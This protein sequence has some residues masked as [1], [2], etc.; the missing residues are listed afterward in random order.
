MSPRHLF[1]AAAAA[2]VLLSG[3]GGGGSASSARGRAE[4]RI[5]WPERSRYLPAYADR[6]TIKLE[7]PG[8]SVNRYEQT[9]TRPSVL[10]ATTTVKFEDL[11]KVGTYNVTG[12]AFGTGNQVVA[13]GSTTLRVEADKTATGSMTLATTI[14]KLAVLDTPLNLVV[15]ANRQLE[16]K[17][18]DSADTVLLIPTDALRWSITSGTAATVSASGMLQAVAVGTAK[19][20]VSETG[21][22]KFAEADIT[23]VNPGGG[24]GLGDFGWSVPRG[25][26]ANTGRGQG[27]GATGATQT[28]LAGA[29][30][31][32]GTTIGSGG[33][34]Y[35]INSDSGIVCLNSATGAA[36][37]T[38]NLPTPVSGRLKMTGPVV[39]TGS[40]LAAAADGVLYKLNADT[41]AKQWEYRYAPGSV[42]ALPEVSVSPDGGTAYITGVAMKMIA[43][44]VATG[45]EKWTK[46][47]DFGVESAPAIGP[48]GEIYVSAGGGM[49][50]LNPLNGAVVWS[51]SEGS[52]IHP[53]MLAGS[54]VYSATV[55]NKVVALNTATGAK[56][57]DVSLSSS[58]AWPLAVTP[59]GR[60]VVVQHDGTVQAF[61]AAAGGA[62]LWTKSLGLET[63]WGASAA[64]D[65]TLYVPLIDNANNKS[66]IHAMRASDGGQVFRTEL[67]STVAME[68]SI[69]KDGTLFT[70]FP[71][72]VKVR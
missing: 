28:A 38:F 37:W 70:G 23:V 10:P 53:V 69:A 9:V 68:I 46:P 2:C 21:A 29:F 55:N 49:A 18:T 32:S 41:G 63:T 61:D 54:L 17:V 22:A 26:I 72:V 5:T 44:D 67:S 51:S 65:G 24:T 3:C 4:F 27:S 57:W 31:S 11:L 30:S 25:D 19:V 6:I 36:V 45:A 12:E 14:D 71:T 13:R 58:D 33:R 52:S 34:V 8:D 16:A 62:A 47:V 40:V 56:V 43:V 42:F 60:I 59:G 35:T 48:G 66:Y 64:T 39:I 15:G 50:R 1:C 20:R 7:L